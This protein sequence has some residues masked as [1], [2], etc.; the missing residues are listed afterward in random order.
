LD[1]ALCL[2]ELLLGLGDLSIKVNAAL[3]VKE[4]GGLG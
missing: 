4:N 2:V 3:D 1:I